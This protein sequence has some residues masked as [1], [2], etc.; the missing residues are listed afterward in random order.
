MSEC[1]EPSIPRVSTAEEILNLPADS[2]NVLVLRLDDTK[3]AALT[4]LREL[5]ALY[6]DG[7]PRITDAGLKHIGTLTDL[8]H[9]DLE[10]CTEI[11]DRGLEALYPLKRLIWLDLFACSGLTDHG[12]ER[13]KTEL[14][15]CEIES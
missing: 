2:P 7:S 1:A 15:D 6:Q 4:R 14:P 13:L 11:T 12:I 5:G 10:W 9:L 8:Q 3:A